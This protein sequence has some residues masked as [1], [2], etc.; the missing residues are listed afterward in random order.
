MSKIIITKEGFKFQ[1]WNE[2]ED[3]H[4]TITT[5][6]L[7][8]NIM[9]LYDY[10]CE[11]EPG[12]NLRDIFELVREDYDRWSVIFG[13][14]LK[15]I[16]EDALE[17]DEEVE[18]VEDDIQYI[19][20]YWS[21]DVCNDLDFNKVTKK[22]KS[23]NIPFRLDCHGYAEPINYS[24][25]WSDPASLLDYE[26]RV[27]EKYEPYSDKYDKKMKQLDTY[28]FFK[29]TLKPN[30]F[31]VLFGLFDEIIHWIGVP[32]QRKQNKAKLD[33]ACEEAEE[34]PEKSTIMK[35]D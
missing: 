30:L 3:W 8:D 13:K 10:I 7:P 16:I 15:E 4:D 31:Q 33:R 20:L 32:E 18:K 14:N 24:F 9:L 21:N 35:V 1:E 5:T 34:F 28:I 19:E 27:N 25:S 2:N 26:V 11:I 22:F 6:K 12:V 17:R 23:A 29:S